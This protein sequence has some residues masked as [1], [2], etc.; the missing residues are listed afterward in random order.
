MTRAS[1]GSLQH[2]IRS[3]HPAY[4]PYMYLVIGLGQAAILW[5][6][7]IL[8]TQ[9]IGYQWV[10]LACLS[11]LSSTLSIKIPAT[12]SKISI[13]DSLFFT[14]TILF[15]VAPGVITAALE[16]LV[17]SMRSRSRARRLHFALFNLAALAGSAWVSSTVFFR[18]MRRGPLYFEPDISAAEVFFPLGILALTHYVVNSGSIAIIVALEKRGNMYRVW[19]ESFLWTSVTYCAGAAAA[20]FIAVVMREVALQVIAIIV[21]VLLAVHFTYRTYLDKVAELQR[22]RQT[23]EEKVHLRTLELKAATDKALELAQEAREA[24]RAKSEFLANMSHEIRTPMN[25]VLGMTELLLSTNLSADQR[26]FAMTVHQSAES[27]LAIINDILDLSKIEAGKLKLETVDFD[28][29]RLVEDIAQLFAD[30]A[31][32]KG[33]NLACSIS[34]EVP[35][36]LRGDPVRLRQILTNLLGNAVKF[37]AKGEVVI[38]VTLKELADDVMVR[39]EVR[40]TGIGIPQALQARIFDAFSQADGST[41]RR[42]GGTGLGLS[43]VKQL[44]EM[45]GGEVGVSSEA[46]KGSTFWFTARL[47]KSS[48]QPQVRHTGT[49]LQMVRVLV[50]DQNETGRN[51]LI[52]QTTSWG[53][54]CRSAGSGRSAVELL[55]EAAVRGEP[56]DV[57]ILD[58]DLQDIDAVSLARIIHSDPDIPPV[59]VLVMVPLAACNSD[60]A[61]AAGISAFVAK[62]HRKSQLYNA[63]LSAMSGTVGQVQVHEDAAGRKGGGRSSLGGRVL[64]AEDHPVNQ[65]VAMEILKGLGCTVDLAADGREVLRKASEGSHDLILMDCQMPE[66]DGYE[67]TRAL[68]E[69]ERAGQVFSQ[70]GPAQVPSHIP[71]VALTAHAVE[72]DRERCLEAG[73]DDY[74]SK[75]FTEGQ[76][77]EIL[78]RWLP[79]LAELVGKVP[80]TKDPPSL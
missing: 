74:L 50:A 57:A 22:L 59:R 14:N 61:D 77:A 72:G 68:R 66:M 9:N 2:Q 58:A 73:M 47:P 70:D 27:L 79:A 24:S 17:G 3:A 63:I 75:P 56:F 32:R 26:R 53:M 62:P 76:L 7:Y 12:N 46:G 21:P 10:L 43:I 37:T 25:G 15:G 80:G 65:M 44:T 67:A 49:A 34:D 39:F 78:A 4:K 20:G 45:M 13:G 51:I 41:T 35:M 42:Y 48:S 16:G 31:H 11:I 23:L 71:I 29:H 52:N 18:M 36:M 6:S 40:D 55:R 60:D 64:L 30:G 33:L 54:R 19:K 28:V 1:G 5:A 69:M 8:V 38:A